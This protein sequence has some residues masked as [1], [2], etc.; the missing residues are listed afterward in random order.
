[1]KNTTV[2]LD[3][4][5][6]VFQAHW[7]DETTGE[8]FTKKLSRAKMAEFFARFPKSTVVMEACGSAHH[9]ARKLKS[10]GHEVK[11]ISAQF[12]RPYVKTNKTDEADAQGIWEAAQR[13]GMRFVAVKSEDQ[14]AVLA[15]H[16]MR[17]LLVKFRTMQS[18]QLR[19]ILYE[20]GVELPVGRW[21]LMEKA[22]A[23]IESLKD[24]VPGMTL[25]ALKRQWDRLKELELEVADLEKRL[26]QWKKSDQACKRVADVPG[27][28]LLTATAA[29][30]VMGD[31]GVFKS[32]REFAAFLGLVP[33]QTGTGGKIRQL[34]MSKRGDVYL[35]TLLI[36][37]ARSVISH[38]REHPAWLTN[39]LA[40]RPKNVAA[41]ALAAKTARTIWALLA[42]ERKFEKNYAAIQAA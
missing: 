1:M 40:R 18:N 13:P 39:I 36:H 21:K 16:R 41:V 24:N 11:L 5:K 6:R 27:V 7:V 35:R 8:I 12:V 31:A 23:A 32:G 9:W 10:F 15:L 20:F 2:G 28:G 26:Q 38:Q 4:A 37:G 34:G 42:H 33:R 17:Q 29:V 22:P 25:D 14:Q 19:G 3:L 30:A